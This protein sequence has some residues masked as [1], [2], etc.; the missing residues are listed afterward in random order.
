MP[1][2]PGDVAGT[3]SNGMSACSK[4]MKNRTGSAYPYVFVSSLLSVLALRCLHAW[5]VPGALR[6]L[7]H[8]LE[9]FTRVVKCEPVV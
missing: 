1:M 7:L 4:A 6:R 8:S 3:L 5:L 2:M 9:H